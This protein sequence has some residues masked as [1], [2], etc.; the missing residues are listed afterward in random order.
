MTPAAL[1]FFL[2]ALQIDIDHWR[3]VFL[4]I[5]AIWGMESA[6]RGLNAGRYLVSPE[7]PAD[8]GAYR[9]AMATGLRSR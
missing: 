6:R 1:G 2:Q 5:G 9:G 3:F 7:P 4:M 8:V